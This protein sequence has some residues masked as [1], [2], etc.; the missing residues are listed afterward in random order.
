VKDCSNRLLATVVAVLLA[1]ASIVATVPLPSKVATGSTINTGHSIA[2]GLVRALLLNEGT[3][4]PAE[5]VG[6][7]TGTA[8]ASATWSTNAN[9]GGTCA[10]TTA[11]GDAWS[12]GQNGLSYGNGDF[13]VYFTARIP[14]T[15]A[16]QHIAG[17]AAGS[18]T[19]GI[20]WGLHDSG[21]MQL[22]LA[23][24]AA[25]DSGIG[26][27]TVGDIYS[28][29]MVYDRGVSVRFYGYNQ[30]TN[31]LMAETILT[32]ATPVPSA[33][34]STLGGRRDFGLSWG[35]NECI[36]L[37]YIWNRQVL[38]AEFDTLNTSPYIF[39]NAPSAGGP[40]LGTLRLLGVGR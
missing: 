32:A 30:T 16:R 7:G 25:I 21:G 5:L 36:G 13:S 37:T 3:G 20:F 34:P 31:T 18:T 2:S 8:Q 26:A 1:V 15:A 40:P 4:S 27:L 19:D 23:D 28:I 14:A 10:L 22:V 9:L 29:G 6:A 38:D 24:V 12:F 11:V 39:V 17:E 33:N 35:G